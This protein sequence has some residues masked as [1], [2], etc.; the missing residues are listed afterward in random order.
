MLTEDS[1]VIALLCS[2]LSQ[3][4]RLSE[5]VKPLSPSE[6]SQ[7][8]DRIAE[9]GLERPSALVG[10]T[11]VE[12]CEGLELEQILAE[13]V[14]ALLDRGVQLAV[15]LERLNSRGIWVLTQADDSYPGKLSQRL[16]HRA[17]PVLFGAGPVELLSEPGVAVVGSRDVDESAQTFAEEIG[18]RCA[19]DGLAVFSGGARGVDR[20]AMTACLECS[21][22]AVGI[23]ADSLERTLLDPTVREYIRDERLT[24][25]SQFHPSSPFSVGKAMGRNPLIYCLSEY[26]VVV[27]SALEKGGSWAGAEQDLKS[28]WVPLFVR[29]GSDIP[30]GNQE[31]IERG[32]IPLEIESL[33]NDESFSDWLR[34]QAAN[35]KPRRNRTERVQQDMLF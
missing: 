35:W 6:W 31:L 8:A 23:L 29:A 1:Q 22:F 21:G 27:D 13:R 33:P 20:V 16:K 3:G 5:Q 32:G 15:E 17:P 18:R 25:G 12:I 24:L 19:G 4:E 28:G 30:A 7:L 2:Q 34:D 11:V 26:A 9:A 14:A 10:R